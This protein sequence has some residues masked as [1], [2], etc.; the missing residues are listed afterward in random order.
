MADPVAD[1]L[2][3]SLSGPCLGVGPADTY[4]PPTAAGGK[5]IAGQN[6]QK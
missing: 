3:L 6:D 2:A 5:E 4:E 1:L